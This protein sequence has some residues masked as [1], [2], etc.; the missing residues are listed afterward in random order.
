M[1]DNDSERV[2]R[3]GIAIPERECTPSRATISHHQTG[4]RETLMLS[5]NDSGK[6]KLQM[7]RKIL[8]RNTN[9]AKELKKKSNKKQKKR[10]TRRRAAIRKYVFPNRTL[11]RTR[12]FLGEPRSAA[13]RVPHP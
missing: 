7:L 5:N 9:A 6:K 13:T 3:F 10:R 8:G 1:A 4:R 2:F 12:R 11:N